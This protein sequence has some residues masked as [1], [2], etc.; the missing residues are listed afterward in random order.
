VEAAQVLLGDAFFGEISLSAGMS[1]DGGE[2]LP[3]P[4]VAQTAQRDLA[5]A[6]QTGLRAAPGGERRVRPD[7][8]G[9]GDQQVPFAAA[10]LQQ[11]R[12]DLQ[13]ERIGPL[14]VV[15]LEDERRP[16][17][18]RHEARGDGARRLTRQGR[19]LAGRKGEG[20]GRRE[21]MTCREELGGEGDPQ[22]GLDG[23][24]QLL[25]PFGSQ[26]GAEEIEEERG[27][28]HAAAAVV[29]EASVEAEGALAPGPRLKV[30]GELGFADP[31]V[32][33]DEQRGRLAGEGAAVLGAERLQL[34]FA[35]GE[36]IEIEVALVPFHRGE[37]RRR[38]DRCALHRSDEAVPPAVKGLDEPAV[39]RWIVE[40]AADQRHGL[41]EDA[42]GHEGVGPDLVQKLLLADHAARMADQVAEDAHG[43]GLQRDDIVASEEQIEA[44]EHPELAEVIG[45]RNY[46][47]RGG[48]HGGRDV[49]RS[50]ESEHGLHGMFLSLLDT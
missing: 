33:E 35:S 26:G 42:V 9:E 28:C 31:G 19:G 21:A 29:E 27:R 23:G 37:G 11:M 46:G 3:E 50:R 10:G 34:G 40:G 43:A 16:P 18:Q 45:L 12:S 25:G 47:R 44:G 39:L 7:R 24:A 48:R 49:P 1:E 41:L 13:C 15:E 22:A 6:A 30:A 38:G 4:F 20:L 14:Q 17:A 32:A 8:A 2:R 36:L 5:E